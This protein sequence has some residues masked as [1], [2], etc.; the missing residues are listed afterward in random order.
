MAVEIRRLPLPASAPHLPLHRRLFGLGSVFG[1]S[2]RDARLGLFAVAGLLGVMAAA[3]GMTMSATYGTPEA[4]LELASMSENMPAMMRGMY[5]NPVN[6]DTLGGFISWHYGPYFALIAGLWSILVLSSTLAG[7]ARRGSLE[8]AVA[9]P[10]SRWSIALQ[11]VLGH[12]AAMGIAVGVVALVAWA[13]GVVSGTFPGDSIAPA[14]AFSF[15][16]GIA[17]RGLAAGSVA[18]ALGPF[19]GRGAAAGIAGAT[20]LGGYVVNSY[21]TVVPAFDAL[22]HASWFAWTADHLPL[23]GQSAWSG[24]A[25]TA[26]VSVV[27][28]TL[29]IAAFARRDVGVTVSLPL[30]GLPRALLGVHGPL[31]RSFGELL[32]MAT[33]WGVGLGIYGVLMAA[34]S[35]SVLDVLRASPAMAEIFRT[36]IPGIDVTTAAG[37]LQLAFADFGFLLIGLA[38]TTFVAAR[39]AD[40][41]SGRLELQLSTPLTRVRWAAASGIAVWLAIALVV[42]LL[43]AAVALGVAS[44]GQDAATPA[45]GTLVLAL[46]GAALAG[47]GVAVGGV[48]RASFAAAAVLAVTIGTFLADLLASILRLPDWVQ[49]LALTAH[50]GEPMVGRWDVAGIAACAA[51]AVGGLVVGAWGMGRRDVG[52]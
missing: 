41:T 50:L 48:S 27:L 39:S 14:A 7:E 23:A 2:L 13:T 8:F 26:L 20:M 11:K 12:V 10:L 38:A 6:V 19:L 47:I 25:F 9:T 42:A 35:G 36:M 29:G 3:G 18:F 4:R 52:A 21:R 24:V 22:S 44:V 33:A 31:D 5:G 15:G 49:Q 16:I 1:K 37:F 17:V 45:A 51:L 28:V 46:Y 40:E 32:P 43:V 30:P 34:A